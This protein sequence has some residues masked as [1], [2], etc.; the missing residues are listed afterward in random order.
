MDSARDTVCKLDVELGERVLGVDRGVRKVTDGGGL[1]DVAD[2]ESLDGLVLG[3]SAGA[4]GAADESDVA[5]AVLVAASV[6]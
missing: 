2:S 5:T 1:D 6:L 3:D 4:V